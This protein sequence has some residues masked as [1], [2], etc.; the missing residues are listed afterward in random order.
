MRRVN[1]CCMELVGCFR[2]Q[3]LEWVPDLLLT[4]L[5]S[6]SVLTANRYGRSRNHNF[7]F[8]RENNI[9]NIYNQRGKINVWNCVVA[10]R[11]VI[12]VGRIFDNLVLGLSTPWWCSKRDYSVSKI[13]KGG[14]GGGGWKD[15]YV[16]VY[17]GAITKLDCR[18]AVTIQLY[19]N[20]TGV[21]MS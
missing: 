9:S 13:K 2:W 12:F 16:W 15:F 14:G 21:C 7:L 20:I 11:Y 1:V 6:A 4:P 17:F 19:H 18:C 5:P 8:W 3:Q 10:E